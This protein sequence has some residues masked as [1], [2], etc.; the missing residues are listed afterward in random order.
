MIEEI[1]PAGVASREAFDDAV[2]AVLPPDEAVAVDRAVAKRRREFTTGRW[3]AR[4]ALADLGAAP[5]SIPRGDD[6]APRWPDGVIGSITHCPGYRAA[7][8]AR[9]GRLRAIGV[10]AETHDPLPAGVIDL[11]ASGPERDHLRRLA[12]GTPVHLDRLLFSAKES[13]Y[14]A[15]YPLAGRWLGFEDAAVTIDVAAGR[16]TARL[17]VPGPRLD[18]AEVTGF[19]GRW[20]VRG[21][22]VLTAV[23]CPAPA[24]GD[25]WCGDPWRVAG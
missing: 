22:L 13:V 16:F 9:V 7:V 20:L 18:G 23:A 14:K 10:D 6:G 11:V 3:C 12:T 2:P 5:A 24:T 19:A 21:G 15:W 8:V 1:L 17:L 25:A 4:A